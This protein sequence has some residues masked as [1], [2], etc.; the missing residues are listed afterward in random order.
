MQKVA[1][2][3]AGGLGKRMN[4]E[5]PKQFL[6]IAGLPV[7]MHTIKKFWNYDN[8]IQII[9]TI[10]PAHIAFWK[11]LCREYK[12]RI[13]HTVRKGGKT[14]FHSVKNGL[15]GIKPG[16]LVAI[17]DGV[18]P[19]VSRFTIKRCFN[20]AEK[21]GTAVPVI[22][23][24]ESV[25]MIENGRNHMVERSKYKLVQ[26]PQVFKSELLKKA[27]KQEYDSTFTDDASLIE[28][29]GYKINLVEGNIDNIKITTKTDFIVAEAFFKNTK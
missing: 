19:L 28:K 10:P 29:L 3:V 2:I 20:M 13:K 27:Y 21:H 16:N 14:R 6:L 24:S 26:T 18:R 9:V 12:F 17:H 1:L 22:S 11:K 4:A 8:S 25:R 7:L 5:I 23:F 15:R